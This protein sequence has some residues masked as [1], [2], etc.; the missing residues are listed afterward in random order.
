VAE[1]G[2]LDNF[3]GLKI[4]ERYCFL[5]KKSFNSLGIEKDE[6]LKKEPII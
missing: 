3:R 6:N 1:N 4:D 5:A 2:I